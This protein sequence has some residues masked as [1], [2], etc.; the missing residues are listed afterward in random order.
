MLD[1]KGHGEVER[2]TGVIIKVVIVDIK[3]TKNVKNREHET[4]K[5][6]GINR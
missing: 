2:N 6:M 4:Q 3:Y 1:H 5:Q